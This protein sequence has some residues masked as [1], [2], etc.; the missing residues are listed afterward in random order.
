MQF[1]CEQS[2]FVLL[3]LKKAVVYV[4]W[5]GCGGGEGAQIVTKYNQMQKTSTLTQQETCEFSQG[6]AI[7]LWKKCI[8]LSRQ[9]TKNI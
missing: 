6:N 9:C 8:C 1:Q 3:V 2:V 7:S 4:G 5:W